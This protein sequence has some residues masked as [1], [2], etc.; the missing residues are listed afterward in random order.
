[1]RSRGLSQQ[2]ESG[3]SGLVELVI[4]LV[5]LSVLTAILLPKFLGSSQAAQVV[6]AESMLSS[7]TT[8]AQSS[9][10]NNGDA[11]FTAGGTGPGTVAGD[12]QKGEPGIQVV[13]AISADNI[14][15][16]QLSVD[17]VSST[18]A[19]L[20]TYSKGALNGAGA[21][22]Y[23]SVNNSGSSGSYAAPPGVQ[24]AVGSAGIACTAQNTPAS[25]WSG[26]QPTAQTVSSPPTGGTVVT[27]PNETSALFNG[28]TGYVATAPFNFTAAYSIGC[29]FNHN[30]VAWSAAYESLID[31]QNGSNYFVVHNGQLEFTAQLTSGNHVLSAGAAPIS[32]WHYAVAVSDGTTMS[33]YLDGVL[34][35]SA[36]A[37][38]VPVGWTGFS[39]LGGYNATVSLLK[40]NIAQVAI[41]SSP[42][43]STQISSL[44]SSMA[45]RNFDSVLSSL[46]PA[47]YWK[48]SDAAGGTMALDWSGNGNTGTANGGVTFGQP[49]P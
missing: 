9:F 19:I 5:I 8:E 1:M 37:S 42:L 25:G 23:V 40:G 44:Y 20:G 36:A 21:C 24:R 17:P 49:G 14:T 31:E 35:N 22:V 34:S 3:V 4:A 43:T 30:G 33:V 46:S 48:L 13:V 45:A 41:F 12:I 7:A 38:G 16:N 2:G 26:T 32:G 11:F 10:H 28:T 39:E 15:A 18:Q 47:G 27:P 6:S 29:W